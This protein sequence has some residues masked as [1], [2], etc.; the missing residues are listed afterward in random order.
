VKTGLHGLSFRKRDRLNCKDRVP[1]EKEE[2]E[3]EKGKNLCRAIPDFNQDRDI[4]L[5][6]KYLNFVLVVS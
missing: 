2:E 1:M 6:S 5:C 4:V 3:E